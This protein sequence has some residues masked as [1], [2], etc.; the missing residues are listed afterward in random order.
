MIH[1]KKVKKYIIEKVFIL[2]INIQNKSLKYKRLFMFYNM[3]L[4]K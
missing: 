1:S 4:I 3:I 2:R